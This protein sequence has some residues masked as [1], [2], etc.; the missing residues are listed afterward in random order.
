M[1]FTPLFTQLARALS[2]ALL[3]FACLYTGSQAYASAIKPEERIVTVSAD[4]VR[5][6][7]LISE[8][9]KQTGCLVVYSSQEV[10]T[11]RQVRLKSRSA[12]AAKL[13]KE[14]F[15]PLGI[16]GIFD[17]NYIILKTV[18]KQDA[19]PAGDKK[20]TPA[21]GRTTVR[22]TVGDAAGAP[23]AGATVLEK[24]SSNGAIS[25]ADGSFRISVA[26][27]AVLEVSFL[28]Y[29]KSEVPVNGR[30]E[31]QV[32]LQEGERLIDEVVVVGY[33]TQDKKTLTGSVSVVKM[34]DV[35]TSSKS[36]VSQS[37]AGRAAGLRVNQISAQA[38]GGVKFRIRGELSDMS[39]SPLVVI[40]GLPVTESSTLSSGNIYESGSTD[41][42]LG[43]LNPDDIESITVLKDAA[44][45]AIYGSRAG[46][47][48]ILITTKRGAKER[49]V[50]SY[51][52]NVSVQTV[53]KHYEMLSAR[54]YMDMYN[55]QSYEEYL[56]TYALGMY[57]RFMTAP[58]GTIP[59]Y[60]PAY[61]D[62]QIKHLK[63]TD[64][65]DEV[66]RTGILHQHNVSVR[67]GTESIRYMAS[68]NY[69]KQQGIIRGNTA[70]RITVR[71]NLDWDISKWVS[72]GLTATYSQNKYDNIPLGEG[73]HE[74][75]GILRA[76]AMANPTIPIRDVNGNYSI[77]PARPTSP[78]P[79]SLLEITDVS[80]FDRIM[81]SAF[82]TAKPVEGLELKFQLGADR[83]F[84]K[85][86]SY[87]PK[88]VLEGMRRNGDAN[89]RQREDDSY[90][91]D[92]TATY[93]KTF[94]KHR[95]KVLAGYSYEKRNYEYVSARNTDFMID[96]SLYY[97]L[98]AGQADKPEVGSDGGRK[99]L[100]SY[101]GR[102]NYDYEQRY[103]LEVSMRAD[104]D[105]NFHPDYRWGI[106]PSVAVGWV[107]S[108]EKF[109]QSARGWLSNLKIRASFGETG[110]SNVPYQVY[111][112]FSIQYPAAVIGDKI[113]AGITDSTVGNSKLTWETTREFNL[114]IDIGF[115]N[116]RYSLAF[117]YYRRTIRDL[118]TWNSLMYYYP[119]S[120]VIANG[121]VTRGTGFE[122]TLNTTNIDRNDF[123][124][125]TT[126]TASRYVDRWKERPP[127]WKPAPYQKVDD[128]KTAW[129]SYKSLG[130]M[131]A[132]ADAPPIHQTTLLPG[133]VMLLD[134]NN[135]KTL[136]DRDMVYMGA[137][138]PDLFIGL[139]N[140]LRWKNLDFS[141]YFYGEFGMTRGASYMESWTQML[142]GYNV[143][144]YAYE[145]YTNSN[146]SGTRPSYI[147]GGNGWGDFYTQDVYYIRCGNINLGYTIPVDKKFLRNI[148]IYADV[149]NPFVITNWK[150]LDPETD[151]LSFSYPNVRTYTVGLNI[152]F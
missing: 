122:L 143:T 14:V 130:L 55:R 91:M 64:W 108:E 81:G 118:I 115:K 22:G 116:N 30:T 46:H 109:M 149:S 4:T 134:K 26:P 56:R 52:G 140:S 2:F 119:V 145:A 34:T 74:S 10:D 127:Y 15:A 120:S 24:G 49:P 44:S 96:G 17:N 31:L 123:T 110:N 107:V 131:P 54:Q 61:T 72:A 141:I 90:L 37:L 97:Q 63:G 78:N 132:D 43:S 136:D 5:I 124:W 40:D 25:G 58:S 142:N 53:A 89:I 76:A 16:D 42:L 95:L 19:A 129:W 137:S 121:G 83:Q 7:T 70:Q 106:F 146:R 69:M 32:R 11:S 45:T 38:G 47:G 88:T 128:Q 113:V 1:N 126:F 50:V 35:E 59:E 92:L 23:I 139:N 105:S 104:G 36:T 117:E 111:D 8:I 67:G 57:S 112:S 152:T 101:F 102:I 103:L 125:N 18:R 133:M 114:G 62:D 13:I 12:T 147:S 3:P 71:S 144:R 20:T 98:W 85:R 75:A 99:T 60:V 94:G 84:Q 21:D 148:R 9:E 73:E 27:D 68:A 6:G 151:N 100:S 80:V 135:D 86:S 79:V 29:L 77:D 82:V 138:A 93:T 33:G 41:N 150:G 39:N 65:T 48:V 51:S 28:G 66:A 87:L